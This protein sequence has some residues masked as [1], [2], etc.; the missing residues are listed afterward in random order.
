MSNLNS[1]QWIP[2]NLLVISKMK[3][4]LHTNFNIKSI[5]MSNVHQTLQPNKKIDFELEAELLQVSHKTNRKSRMKSQN[6]CMT[7]EWVANGV[8]DQWK[9]KTGNVNF[10]EGKRTKFVNKRLGK[11]KNVWNWGQKIWNR[12]PCNPKQTMT[13][14]VL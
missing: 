8:K 13:F 14:A 2:N 9:I 1:Q 3:K 4:I 12:N 7:S 5:T 11:E 10:E 6:K